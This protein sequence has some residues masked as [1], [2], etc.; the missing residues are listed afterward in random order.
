[1]WEKEEM[2]KGDEEEI[3][4]LRDKGR[5]LDRKETN[6]AYRIMA[7]YKGKRRNLLLE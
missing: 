6:M 2:N 5:L 1:M 4:V 3:F 7:V